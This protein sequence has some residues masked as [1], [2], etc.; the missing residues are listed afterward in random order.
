MKNFIKKRL[1]FLKSIKSMYKYG[2]FT[3]VNVSQ[4]NYGDI[5]QG[6]T[7]LITG[8]SQ[9]IGLAICMAILNCG[10]KVII[11]GRLQEKLNKIVA[12]INHPNL[13][14]YEWDVT[15]TNMISE[16]LRN[17][18]CENIDIL[19]NNAGVYSKTHFP[20]CTSEDWD[21]VYATNAKATFF[22]CQEICKKWMACKTHATRKIITSVHKVV[23]R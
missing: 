21:T 2:G 12:E 11:T 19:I 10:G 20:H 8:G 13:K 5:L 6:K 7:I 18:N 3:K 15:N 14:G 1:L 16:H 9:G 22:I 4:V 17:L 23:S